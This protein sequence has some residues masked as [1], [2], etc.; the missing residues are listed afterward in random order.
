MLEEESKNYDLKDLRAMRQAAR[1]G[2]KIDDKFEK[3]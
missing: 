1:S 3:V 2:K